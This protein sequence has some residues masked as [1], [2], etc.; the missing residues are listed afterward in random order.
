MTTTASINRLTAHAD[1]NLTSTD[2]NST[3]HNFQAIIAHL[4]YAEQETA[5]L[6]I[7]V[8][9]GLVTIIKDISICATSKLEFMIHTTTQADPPPWPCAMHCS[10]LSSHLAWQRVKFDSRVWD[11]VQ[12]MSWVRVE[13]MDLFAKT[14]RTLKLWVS[15][16]SLKSGLKLKYHLPN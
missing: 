9:R 12:V 10:H 13:S 3:S 16:L 1:I 7:I 8:S 4:I 11:Q 5:Y 15:S 6:F 14:S 2:N